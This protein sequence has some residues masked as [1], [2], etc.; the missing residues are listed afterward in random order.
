LDQSSRQ[1]CLNP[2]KAS[3]VI[4]TLRGH[5]LS[6]LKLSIGFY[7]SLGPIVNLS[8]NLEVRFKYIQ[9]ATRTGQICEVEY[10][11]RERHHCNAE[12]LESSWERPNYLIICYLLP[13]AKVSISSTT[14]YFTSTEWSNSNDRSVCI[15]RQSRMYTTSHRPIY[16][17]WAVIK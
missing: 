10:N 9:A 13:F 3:K 2:S 15:T 12:N 5:K 8:E 11:S 17:L 14:F 6:I 4:C 7:Y 1:G 16:L